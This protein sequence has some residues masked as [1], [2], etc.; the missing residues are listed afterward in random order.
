[1][2]ELKQILEELPGMP[3]CYDREEPGGTVKRLSDEGQAPYETHHQ[4]TTA[5]STTGLS[6]ETT[7]ERVRRSS[8]TSETYGTKVGGHCAGEVDEDEQ[9]VT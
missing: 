3:S 8:Q 6:G 1:M 5:S 4:T 2:P 9:D 7:D